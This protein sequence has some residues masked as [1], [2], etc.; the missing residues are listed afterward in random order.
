MSPKSCGFCSRESTCTTRSLSPVLSVPTGRSWF[1]LRTAVVTCSV[2]T[3]KASMAEGLSS[4]LMARCVPPTS[5]TEP[6]PFTFSSRFL[7]VCSA[8]VVSSTAL[9]VL[10]FTASGMTATDQMERAAGSN[11]STRGSSTSS[12][13]SGRR[14]PIFSRTSSAA[15]RPSIVSWNSM[16]TIEEPS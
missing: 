12:R 14:M 16:M 2:V 13:S 11:R 8:Q 4:M 1:S 9:G 5:V 15:L 3:P 10:P 6:T 7:K